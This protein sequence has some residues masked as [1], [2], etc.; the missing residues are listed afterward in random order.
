VKEKGY[1]CI[2]LRQF[3]TGLYVETQTRK[4]F[5]FPLLDYF[6]F[7]KESAARSVGNISTKNL[8][9]Q[10]RHIKKNTHYDKL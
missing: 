2:R 5:Q 7:Q 1:E 3:T 4:L 9:K 6:A 8:L 10:V